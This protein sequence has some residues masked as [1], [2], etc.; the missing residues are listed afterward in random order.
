[1]KL[2]VLIV[3]DE[4]RIAE[5]HVAY[6]SRIEGFEVAGAVGTAADG[7]RAVSRAAGAG[8]PVDLVLADVGLPDRSGLDLAGDLAAM[9]PRPDVIVITS[10]RDIDTV[11]TAVARGAMLYLIKPFT[12]AAFAA[13]LERYRDFR[14]TLG[15]GDVDQR[16]VDAALAALRDPA[17]APSTP[18]GLAASTL[19]L[20][21]AAVRDAGEALG[22]GEVASRTGVSRVT[23]WRYLERLADDRVVERITDYG[24]RGRPEV[25]YRWL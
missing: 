15:G 16:D 24:G 14:R 1:M 10:A 19:G 5:A 23:A 9:S 13:K 2:R 3:E 7:I 8:N 21:T 22:A 4:P 20:I 6:V 11:R 17:P 25:R 12:F 18:K